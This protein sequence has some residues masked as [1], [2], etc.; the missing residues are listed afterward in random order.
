MSLADG[1][2]IASIVAAHCWPSPVTSAIINVVQLTAVMDPK[3]VDEYR[4][5]GHFGQ[6]STGPLVRRR[7]STTMANN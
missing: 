7:Y 6:A 2:L 5:G 3:A 1:V 4:V